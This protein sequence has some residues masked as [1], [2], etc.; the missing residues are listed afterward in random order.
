MS[1]AAFELAMIIKS[2]PPLEPT[3]H[4]CGSGHTD[5]HIPDIMVGDGKPAKNVRSF[6]VFLKFFTTCTTAYEV[7]PAIYSLVLTQHSRHMSIMLA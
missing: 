3:C 1:P 4:V 6:G 7:L 2:M 5:H